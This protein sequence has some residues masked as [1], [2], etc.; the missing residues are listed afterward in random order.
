[1]T[2]FDFPALEPI[3]A[4]RSGRDLIRLTGAL[5]GSGASACWRRHAGMQGQSAVDQPI[6]AYILVL[7]ECDVVESLSSVPKVE[8]FELF[9]R[10]PP[11]LHYQG[12]AGLEARPWRLPNVGV[13]LGALL[14]KAARRIDARKRV[15]RVISF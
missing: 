7:G 13:L 1:V 4:L 12:G 11:L 15:I 2:A 9:F 6:Q 3:Y 8:F 5:T 14:I 10:D